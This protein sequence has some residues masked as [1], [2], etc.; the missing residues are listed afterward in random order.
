LYIFFLKKLPFFYP[1]QRKE[2][3][4]ENTC[5]II[6][7]ILVFLMILGAILGGGGNRC[8]YGCTCAKCSKEN[9]AG[10]VALYPSTL[11]A[12]PVSNIHHKNNIGMNTATKGTTA[13]Q[14]G[15]QLLEYYDYPKSF[16]IQGPIMPEGV[17]L[18]FEPTDVITYT[19]K[20]YDLPLRVLQKKRDYNYVSGFIGSKYPTSTAITSLYQGVW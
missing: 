15:L 19:D 3:S 11:P 9:Y 8:G 7:G 10:N 1:I 13:G 18:E 2:M 16:G 14:E 17:E 5:W 6:I 4:G 20:L 12:V